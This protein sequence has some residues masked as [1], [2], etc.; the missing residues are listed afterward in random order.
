MVAFQ[1]DVTLPPQTCIPS[2]HVHEPGRIVEE[3][4]EGTYTAEVLKFVKSPKVV[5]AD[6]KALVIEAPKSDAEKYESL[7]RV[8][9]QVTAVKQL[10]QH[11]MPDWS[12]S[13]GFQI[14]KKK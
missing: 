2:K 5:Y 4:Q 1:T 14:S 10:I 3:G 7:Q 12:Y 9:N 11:Y 6:K 13:G 8:R